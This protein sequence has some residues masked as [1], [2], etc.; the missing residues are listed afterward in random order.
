M[1]CVMSR[2]NALELKLLVCCLDNR[3]SNGVFLFFLHFFSDVIMPF[4]ESLI[5]G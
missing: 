5:G 1:I 3:F 2:L 4:Q